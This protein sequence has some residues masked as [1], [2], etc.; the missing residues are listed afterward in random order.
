MRQLYFQVVRPPKGEG[1][2][3]NR[4]IFSTPLGGRSEEWTV[5]EVGVASVIYM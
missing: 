3:K 1:G 5:P 2:L 4:N